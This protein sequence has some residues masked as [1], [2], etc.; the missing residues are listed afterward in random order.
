M[1]LL[2]ICI[3]YSLCVS[4]SCVPATIYYAFW[5]VENAYYNAKGLRDDDVQEAIH[6]FEQ[7]IV[8]EQQKLSSAGNSGGGET[9]KYG[10]WSYKAMKQ[11]VKLHLRSG[12]APGT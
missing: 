4:V 10:E 3:L 12:N 5:G 11:L 8:E 6:A 7:V 1:F 9:K 2:K